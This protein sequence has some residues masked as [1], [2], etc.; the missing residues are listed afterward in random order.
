MPALP[1]YQVKDAIALAQVNNDKV[2]QF[3]AVN[4]ENDFAESASYNVDELK[5]VSK[6]HNCTI[7][8]LLM[9]IT[10]TSITKHIDEI[11]NVQKG[12]PPPTPKEA[13]MTVCINLRDP[14]QNTLQM[15]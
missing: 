12:P 8:D 3:D 2:R 11:Q 7:N 10:T 9:A 6:Q 5:K 13:A 4:N 14:P 1:Y 15:R